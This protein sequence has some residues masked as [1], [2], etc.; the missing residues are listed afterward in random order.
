MGLVFDAKMVEF[1]LSIVLLEGLRFLVHK[2]CLAE[3]MT[4]LAFSILHMSVHL[5]V[6]DLGFTVLSS[7][8]NKNKCS[9]QFAQLIKKV[10]PVSFHLPSRMTNTPRRAI[11]ARINMTIDLKRQKKKTKK[12]EVM[13]KIGKSHFYVQI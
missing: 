11:L 5:L 6:H 3:K 9:A 1:L 8:K 2:K 4:L 7:F 12:E 13:I 10:C